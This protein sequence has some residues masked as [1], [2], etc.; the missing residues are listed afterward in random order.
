LNHWTLA[1]IACQS[2]LKA[3]PRNGADL[4]PLR[5]SEFRLSVP[6]RLTLLWLSILTLIAA[7]PL[8]ASASS[9]RSDGDRCIRLCLD[10][11]APSRVD[12]E[13]RIA[14][15]CTD[16]W[17]RT[18]LLALAH[19]YSHDGHR[20]RK[21]IDQWLAGETTGAAVADP[22]KCSVPLAASSFRS[23]TLPRKIT[24]TISS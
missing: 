2:K 5:L 19:A 8:T 15:D 1:L 11:T 6:L 7:L 13:H 16:S 4:K 23:S 24:F 21:R 18:R 3:L 9:L 22:A 14:S 20:Q 12:L 17:H 10:F